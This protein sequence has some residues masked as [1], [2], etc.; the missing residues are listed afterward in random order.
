MKQAEV[1]L[2]AR[3]FPGELGRELMNGAYHTLVS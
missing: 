1:S 2:V 3:P